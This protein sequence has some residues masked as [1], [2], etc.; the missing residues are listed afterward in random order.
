MRTVSEQLRKAIT[1]S[2][3]SLLKLS[4]ESGAC[5]QSLM[6]FMRG[7]SMQLTTVDLVAEY[8]GLRLQPTTRRSRR[9]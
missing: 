2:G 7:A 6:A 1:D 5:R 3:L 8:L 9:K 4:R